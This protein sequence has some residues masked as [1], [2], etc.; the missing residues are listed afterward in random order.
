MA[1]LLGAT[2]FS[3][4]QMREARRQRD[5]AVYEQ[6]RADAQVEFQS[7]M[8]SSIGTE[9]VTMREI[10]DQGRVLLDQEFSGQPRLAASIALSLGKAY[11]ELGEH[12]ATLEMTVRAESLAAAGNAPE[13]LALSRCARAANLA[14]RN[15]GA[16]ASALA[17]SL[18]AAIGTLEPGEA[19][20]CLEN[21]AEIELRGERF[22]SAAALASR[23]AA[24]LESAGDTTGVDYIDVLN[25]VANALENQ[26]RR[27][28][29][30]GIYQRLAA[31]MDS[32]GRGQT[33]YR[34]I[35]RNN[36]GIALSN[37]G[38]M[39]AAEPILRETLETFRRGDPGGDVHP[40]IL[41]NYCRTVL[42][43]QRLDTAAVWY[44]H[45]YARAAAR[46]ETDMAADAA[47]GMAQVELARGRLD[48][49]AR[50]IAEE[51]R[52]RGL[53]PGSRTGMGLALEAE[54]AHRRGELPAANAGFTDAL[55]RMGYFDGTRIYQM[56]SVLI[57]GAEAAR[58]GGDPA[59]ATSYGAPPQ[60]SPPRTP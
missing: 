7:L 54:L 45:L 9:R 14:A 12:Q 28:E 25:I 53:G 36:V 35:I 51:R 39:T 41:V 18:R 23:A 6:K 31:M 2:A 13:M 58:D 20:T 8:L 59:R 26:K 4:V 21:L 15:L 33:L 46:K 44:H 10:I 24:L 29:A 1:T 48:E 30:L 56:R 52:T 40:A 55:R 27:R 42:F 49:A 22:D 32:T 34:N 19:A 5:A 47:Y 16:Q 50:W 57:R 37:L 3:T 43:L 38:E 17:D 11:E 60:T